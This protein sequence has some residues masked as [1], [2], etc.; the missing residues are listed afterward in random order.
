M[1]SL[2]TSLFFRSPFSI[3]LFSI[4]AYL[5]DYLSV[6]LKMGDS[7][8][9]LTVAFGALIAALWALLFGGIV[10]ANGGLPLHLLVWSAGA[11]H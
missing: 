5:P 4:Q 11:I 1:F 8:A 9:A 7:N 10:D 6:Y 3:Q 2:S